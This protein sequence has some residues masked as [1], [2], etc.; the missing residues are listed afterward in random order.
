MDSKRR[1]TA[2]KFDD[3]KKNFIIRSG[4]ACAAGVFK[5]V[6]GAM[7]ISDYRVGFFS[8]P[9][10]RVTLVDPFPTDA[11]ARREGCRLKESSAMIGKLQ[12]SRRSVTFS[13]PPFACI[14]ARWRWRIASGLRRL[15][16]ARL[17]SRTALVAVQSEDAE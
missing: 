4:S 6:L 16:R 9:F 11:S 2:L 12:L 7:W 17:Q 15:A 13:H 10:F 8:A 5:V 3:R 14:F 1:D